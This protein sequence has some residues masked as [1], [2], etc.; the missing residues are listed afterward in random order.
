MTRSLFRIAVWASST[1]A[2]T[3]SGRSSLM[4]PRLDPPSLIDVYTIRS[5]G[6]SC[7]LLWVTWAY[8]AWIR[9]R[10][11]ASQRATA[12]VTTMSDMSS[13]SVKCPKT[14]TL[15]ASSAAAN[16]PNRSA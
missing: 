2:L 6:A 15:P 9:S 16:V 13:W 14:R 7:G 3:S 4:A 11:A 8:H 12:L 5:I 1:A 10:N